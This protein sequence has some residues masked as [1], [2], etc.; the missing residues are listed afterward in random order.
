MRDRVRL[1]P[2]CLDLLRDVIPRAGIPDD[3]ESRQQ[4]DQ[5]KPSHWSAA[6][7]CAGSSSRRSRSTRG[8]RRTKLLPWNSPRSG[9]NIPV[10]V[11]SLLRNG[12]LFADSPAAGLGCGPSPKNG[13]WPCSPTRGKK[14]SALLPRSKPSR[15]FQS[16]HCLSD[17]FHLLHV[18]SGL[19]RRTKRN[20]V[21]PF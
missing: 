5:P 4:N 13:A 14:S 1:E 18:D 3:M 16:V 11:F 20:R 9:R 21:W 2:S 8:C 19:V 10:S 7:K 6:A 15:L 12:H 17:R